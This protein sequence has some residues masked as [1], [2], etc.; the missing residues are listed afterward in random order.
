M[1]A[2]VA[3][4]GRIPCTSDPTKLKKIDLQLA[5][6]DVHDGG[7]ILSSLQT[8]LDFELGLE[9]YEYDLVLAATIFLVFEDDMCAE[10]RCGE[11]GD[12]PIESF[13]LNI[14]PV[15]DE[16]MENPFYD[17]RYNTE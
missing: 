11:V 10:E 3:V 14:R 15:K 9:P 6:P 1:S 4:S 13:H 8:L 7:L 16:P 2:L 5:L 17:D 12:D